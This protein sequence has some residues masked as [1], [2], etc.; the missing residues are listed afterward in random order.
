M[1]MNAKETQPVLSAED[2]LDTERKLFDVD[3]DLKSVNGYTPKGKVK[4]LLR[5]RAQ[6]SNDPVKVNIKTKYILGTNQ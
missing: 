4:F 3:S 5:S 1:M 6:P 2:E